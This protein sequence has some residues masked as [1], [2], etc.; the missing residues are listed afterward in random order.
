MFTLESAVGRSIRKMPLIL[1]GWAQP[2]TSGATSHSRSEIMV[3]CVEWSVT[4]EQRSFNLSNFQRRVTVPANTQ[5][6]G[7]TG[8]NQ[9]RLC[10]NSFIVLSGPKVDLLER[11][12]ID[13][14]YRGRGLMTPE[15][16][17]RPSFHTASALTCPPSIEGQVSESRL[18]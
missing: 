6:C 13:H 7:V 10:E 15:N 8:C 1:M 4:E 3:V 16:A 5:A 17:P 12:R 14:R 11:P 18:S 2:I 9:P